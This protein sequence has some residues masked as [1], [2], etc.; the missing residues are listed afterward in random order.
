M[1]FTTYQ[2]KFLKEFQEKNNELSD[3]FRRASII[4][5]YGNINQCPDCGAKTKIDR[6]HGEIYCQDCGLIVRASI[7]YVGNMEVVY[8]YGLLL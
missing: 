5:A 8:P 2:E 3:D 6:A 4:Y 7:M 1:D